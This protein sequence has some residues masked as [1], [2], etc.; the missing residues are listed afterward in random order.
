MLFRE[1]I[2]QHRVHRIV[3][4]RVRFPLLI[5]HDQRGIHFFQGANLTSCKAPGSF[6]NCRSRPSGGEFVTP[7]LR[8]IFSGAATFDARGFQSL[9]N[10]NVY[11]LEKIRS[12]WLRGSIC[13][14]R[15]D[16]EG[17]DEAAQ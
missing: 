7:S 16:C 2:E 1:L 4:D 9:E 5:V 3:A 17:A 6:T 11:E 8:F 15:L 14:R 12:P 13:F 10:Y